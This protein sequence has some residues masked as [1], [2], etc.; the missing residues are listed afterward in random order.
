M[1][2]WMVLVTDYVFP[3]LEVERAVLRAAGAE[4]VAMQA[5]SEAELAEAVGNAD[6]LLVCYAPVTRRVI[7]RA[8]RCRVIARYGIGVDNVD[9]DAATER[10]IV[11]TNVPDYC[12]EEVSDHAL[13]LLL[14]C[15]RKVAFLDRGVRAGRWEARDA[16]PIRRLRGQ[17]LG[18]V[19]FGKIPRLLAAKA[20]ALGLTVL[21]YDPYLDAATC[22]AYGARQVELG[23]LLARADFVSVHAPLTP[24]TRGLIGE[25]EL[26][27][28]KPTAY[29]INTARGPIVHEAALLQALQE[30]WI[31]GAAL[32]VLESEPPPAGHPLLQAPQVVLTPHVAFYSEES[33]QEL[34]RKAAE[35]VAR[36]LTGQ[37]PRYPVNVVQAPGTR[38]GS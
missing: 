34:Q 25:A 7:E 18:L 9:V 21:A 26:R 20:R 19:G 22:E 15:A 6:G 24:Q 38:G 16:V 37:P 23:E 2:R 3:S 5:G 10:G 32:D 30:G 27:R 36:V 13:A 35:E 11:V 14:A 17:V 33:L 8:Q 28:M 29:L 1:G 12:I 4:L 31:A